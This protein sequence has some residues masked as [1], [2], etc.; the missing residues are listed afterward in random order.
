MAALHHVLHE[1]G[2]KGD[3]VSNLVAF[4]VLMMIGLV[5]LFEVVHQFAYEWQFVL[6]Q[7]LVWLLDPRIESLP[8][9]F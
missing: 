1:H 4:R 8:C 7:Q 3:Q 6:R 9:P 2:Q 5:S